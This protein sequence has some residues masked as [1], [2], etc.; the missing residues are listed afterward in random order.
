M[1]AVLMWAAFA[2]S[3]TGCELKPEYDRGDGYVPPD[4]M[5]GEAAVPDDAGAD[6][7]PP[8]VDMAQP[9]G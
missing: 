1:R 9:A 8:P 6:L 4:Y 7:A 2:L 3:V 5:T